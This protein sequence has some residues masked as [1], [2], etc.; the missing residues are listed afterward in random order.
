MG[1]EDA[2]EEEREKEG[3]RRLGPAPEDPSSMPAKTYFFFFPF[4]QEGPHGQPH[5]AFS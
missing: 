5:W 3:G 2:A 4:N 1:W